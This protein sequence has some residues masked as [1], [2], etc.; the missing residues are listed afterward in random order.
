MAVEFCQVHA[1]GVSARFGLRFFA[2]YA[3]GALS[4]R[5]LLFLGLAHGESTKV[6]CGLERLRQGTFEFRTL[7]E[8]MDLA[9]QLARFC[10]D[11]E[12]TLMGLSE[13]MINAVEHGN[14]EISSR[15]KENG[16]AAFLALAGERRATEPYA[17]RRVRVVSRVTQK[18]ATFVITDQGPGFDV[19]SLPDPTDPANL[20]RPSGRGLLLMRTFMDEV[21]Y[22]PAGNRCTMVKLRS[23]E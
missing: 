12:S 9:V 13:L 11:P 16:D 23:A 5:A 17:S 3:R 10:P 4:L 1:R 21:R 20:E 15:L 6:A 18:K 2:L 14:L 22:N 19:S 7:E 8:A